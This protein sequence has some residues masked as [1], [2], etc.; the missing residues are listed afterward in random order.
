MEDQAAAAVLA[1]IEDQPAACLER[2]EA[3]A[4]RG[5][6]PIA[7]R[8]AAWR[9]FLRAVDPQR[10]KSW[11]RTLEDDRGAYTK[12]RDDALRR[13]K[14][15]V[16]G[17]D[18]DEALEDAA[19]QIRKDCERCY[20]DGA[21]DHFVAD[22]KRQKA[23]FDALLTWH[24]NCGEYRQ[25]MHE[26][27]ATI[28][29][30]LERA[31]GAASLYCPV[32]SSPLHALLPSSNDLEADSF[33]L[34]AKLAEVTRPIFDG[35]DATTPSPRRAP[36]AVALCDDVQG[37]ALEAVDEELA[38]HLRNLEVIPQIYVL[39]WLRTLFGRRYATDDVCVVWDALFV[40]TA[41][42]AS[43]MVDLASLLVVWDRGELL[44]RSGADDVVARLLRPPPAPS[45]RLLVGL[46]KEGTGRQLVDAL[47]RRAALEDVLGPS[48][49]GV[50]LGPPDRTASGLSEEEG[51]YVDQ[52]LATLCMSGRADAVG[53]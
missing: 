17:E 34:F 35:H 24:T 44:R 11:R 12:K 43:K 16:D 7:V 6:L 42:L 38:A 41:A 23:L 5:K 47:R 26:V 37:R 53:G 2:L 31:Q 27:L 25:G 29:G 22:P 36:P 46:L 9:L 20:I 28:W 19:D 49:V 40:D 21:G 3:L 8:G 39:S 51:D 1:H 18:N 45:P 48:V 10:P 52:A 13:L 15:S 30:A 14:Q 33:S 4:V 32:P 50:V